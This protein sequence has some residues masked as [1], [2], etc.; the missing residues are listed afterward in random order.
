MET[1]ELGKTATLTAK[2]TEKNETNSRELFSA[3]VGHIAERGRR[4]EYGGKDRTE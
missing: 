3:G 1:R 4:D 2:E